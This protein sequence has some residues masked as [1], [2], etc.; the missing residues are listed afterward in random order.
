MATDNRDTTRTARNGCLARTF[1]ASNWTET[2]M[3]M[4]GPSLNAGPAFHPDEA[5]QQQERHT[6]PV[7]YRRHEDEDEMEEE[8]EQPAAPSAPYGT[9]G[10]DDDQDFYDYYDATY[11]DAVDPDRPTADTYEDLDAN[12]A[13]GPTSST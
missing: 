8:E 1:A 6:P 12:P 13:S 2:E 10:F 7:R 9:G 11:A 5:A 3:E 4:D